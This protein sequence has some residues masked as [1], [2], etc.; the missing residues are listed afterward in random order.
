[1][2]AVHFP[3]VRLRHRFAASPARVY[4]AWVEP[5]LMRRW[6]FASPTN[7]IIAVKSERAPGG[8]LSVIE[9]AGGD[10]IDHFGTFLELDPPRRLV[11]SLEVPK[12]FTGETLVTVEIEPDGDPDGARNGDGAL[13]QFTQTGVRREITEDAW[14]AMF[15][16]LEQMLADEPDP[17]RRVSRARDA[18]EQRVL[19]WQA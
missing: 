16:T 2:S 11:F 1:M 19:D 18:D 5:D 10:T 17:S 7:E 3:P 4:S 14:R 13:M 6:M 15:D 9:R 8:D 12:H